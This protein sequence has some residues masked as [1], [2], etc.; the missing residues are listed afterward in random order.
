M[1]KRA[2]KSDEVFATCVR[3]RAALAARDWEDVGGPFA[4]PAFIAR[5]LDRFCG[6]VPGGRWKRL[7]FFC[8]VLAARND[9]GR[10]AYTM[11]LGF[12]TFH[13][14]GRLEQFLDATAEREAHSATL[15]VT[16]KDAV[17]H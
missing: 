14:M 2:C 9:D 8:D 1:K 13:E 12:L 10:T 6:A 7:D 4:D 17:A 3:E 5:V 16:T 15:S 11:L